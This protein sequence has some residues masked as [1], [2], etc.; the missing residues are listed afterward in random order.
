M[1][2]KYFMTPGKIQLSYMQERAG[3]QGCN[4]LKLTLEPRRCPCN[5]DL[6]AQQHRVGLSVMK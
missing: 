3:L 1:Q 5:P 4:A 6:P 2:N